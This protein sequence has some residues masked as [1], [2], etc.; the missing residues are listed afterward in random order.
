MV[1]V[2]VSRWTTAALL[3]LTLTVVNSVFLASPLAQQPPIVVSPPSRRQRSCSVSLKTTAKTGVL[4]VAAPGDNPSSRPAEPPPGCPPS[5]PA[6]LQ[7]QFRERNPHRNPAEEVEAA[8][9]AVEVLAAQADRLLQM[10]RYRDAIKVLERL[11]KA[12]PED[13]RVWMQLSQGYKRSRRMR[14]AEAAV[15]RGIEACPQNA[16]LRQALGELLGIHRTR[17]LLHRSHRGG[18]LRS[19]PS[20]PR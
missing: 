18:S 8:G 17:N 2:T 4:R 5:V 14:D 19:L 16:R 7:A 9:G 15:R 6:S 11:S 12:T 13:G 20:P 1:T 3:S 10:H